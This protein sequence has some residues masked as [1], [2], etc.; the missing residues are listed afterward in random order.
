MEVD[1]RSGMVQAIDELIALIE[2]EGDG[3]K[4]LHDA[5]MT[6]EVLLGMLASAARGGIRTPL[7]A[8]SSESVLPAIGG[9]A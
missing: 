3:M 1:S 5:R 4:A 2:Q 6:V 9:P 8:S 7:G